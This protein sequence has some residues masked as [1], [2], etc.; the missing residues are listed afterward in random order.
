MSRVTS[1]AIDLSYFFFS[2]TQK[3]LRDAHLDEFLQIY[4]TNLARIIR[5]TGSDPDALFP[6]AELQRQLRQ[7]GILGV[8]KA[9][10]MIPLILADSSEISDLDRL[11]EI[12]AGGRAD[13]GLMANLNEDKVEEFAQQ[14]KDVLSDARRYGWF[15]NEEQNID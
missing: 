13:A 14:L 2:S 8:L 3:S 9:P 6:E 11:A 15:Y 1:P 4:Y 5:R 12:M 10:L 7:F